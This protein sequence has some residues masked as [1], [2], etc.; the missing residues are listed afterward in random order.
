MQM[1]EALVE[2]PDGWEV[3]R[4]M[5]VVIVFR[6]TASPTVVVEP[7]KGQAALVESVIGHGKHW[8]ATGFNFILFLETHID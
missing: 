5:L 3:W 1:P 7:A 2:Y 4:E 6:H 8:I